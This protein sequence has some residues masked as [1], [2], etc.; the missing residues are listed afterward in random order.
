[1]KTEVDLW[2]FIKTG[3]NSLEKSSTLYFLFEEE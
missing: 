1:M 2:K 3:S